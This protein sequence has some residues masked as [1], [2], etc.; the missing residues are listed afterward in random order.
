MK[1]LLFILLVFISINNLIAQEEEDVGWVARFGAAGGI[2]PTFIFPNLDALNKEVKNFG[3][4]ELNNN[5]FLFGGGG[6]VYLMFIENL[7][8]GGIGFGGSQSTNG[9]LI[10]AGSNVQR[11]VAYDFGFGGLTLEY[12]LPFI[13]GVAVSLGGI[14]GGGSQVI[15][16][17]ENKG[18]YTW[19]NSW[20]RSGNSFNAGVS[21]ELKNNF[22]SI[23]PTLNLDLPLSRF[24]AVRVGA[25][26]FVNFSND[27]KI[28]NDQNII[29]VPKDLTS[30][31]FFIQTGIYFGFIA[32]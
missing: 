19:D 16:I 1:K 27:W 8:I 9:N 13:K 32:F 29:G 26:Y 7:R 23:S 28:N 25:G 15:S 12:T 2:S 20:P 10:I 11:E 31:H 4:P 21:S 30:N 3:L 22:F 6:Y 5:L 17:Y 18:I 24:A 14:I